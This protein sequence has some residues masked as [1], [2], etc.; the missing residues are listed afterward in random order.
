MAFVQRDPS[1]NFHLCFRFGGRRFKRSLHTKHQRK[2]DAA[3]SHVE[4][5]LRLVG[6]GRLDLP[7]NVD[8]PTF[9]LS[10]GKLAEKP[11]VASNIKLGLLFDEYQARTPEGALEASSI[12]TFRTHMGHV[13]RILGAGTLLRSIRTSDL[14]RYVTTR[15]K[16]KGR[17]DTVSPVTIRKEL[18]TFASLWNWARTQELTAGEFPRKGIVFGKHED[19]PPFQTWNQ[20]ERQIKRDGLNAFQAEPLWESLYLSTDEIAKLLEHIHENS[21]YPFLHPMCVLAAYTGARRS[22]LCRARVADFDFDGA[23]VVIRERKRSRYKR[24]TRVVPLTSVAREV[25]V[26][27]V[28]EKEPSVIMFP[29][30][31]RVERNRS[32]KLEPGAVSPNE[33][34][35]RLNHVL[36][37]SKWEPIPGWHV[38]RHSFISNCASQGVDQRFIDSWV[39]HQTDEQ[40]NRYRHLFPDSQQQAID[41]VFE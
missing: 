20:I 33:A 31:H 11:K 38:F 6:E 40:R 19:K 7:D 3:A 30:D 36:A 41:S 18:A 13:A 29:E 25:L 35:E 14:Q 4:E 1:G 5:N 8:V 24:T 23:M 15:S 34:S 39:G 21:G 9:L 16:E 17:R 26:S 37:K 22:E 12:Q 28:G 32:S 10:D 27:W 2:A